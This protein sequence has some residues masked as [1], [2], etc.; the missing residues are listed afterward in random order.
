M[1]HPAQIPVFRMVQVGEAAID[2]ARTKF[3]VIAERAWPFTIRRGS[4][5]RSSTVNPGWLMKSPR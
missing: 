4:A 1:P 3:M 2:Q 5:V